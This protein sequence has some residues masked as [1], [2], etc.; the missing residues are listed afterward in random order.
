[1]I[2]TFYGKLRIP[3][4]AIQIEY[5][6]CLRYEDVSVLVISISFIL[7]RTSTY[8]IKYVAHNPWKKEAIRLGLNI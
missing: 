2:H 5:L 1:M 3:E 8:K 4:V 6:A 7:L